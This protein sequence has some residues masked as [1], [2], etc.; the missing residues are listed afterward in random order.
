M[1]VILC[2]I[3]N[4]FLS[5]NESVVFFLSFVYVCIAIEIQLSIGEVWDP[6]NWFIPAIFLCPSQ[7]RILD[8]QYH[9]MVS[10]YGQRVEV[11][12][13]CSFC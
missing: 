11:R 12:G 4:C 8:C 2:G 13:D 7:V 5:R 9:V 3:K 10:L 1:I 6:I